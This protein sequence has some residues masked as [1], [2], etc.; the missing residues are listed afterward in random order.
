[1]ALKASVHAF[2]LRAIA[3]ARAVG[4]VSQA[5]REF[6]IARTLF[7]RWRRRYLAY[8]SDGLYPKRA[9]PRRGRPPSLSVEAERAILAVALAWPT[10]GPAR[11]S[12]HLARCEDGAWNLAPAT[13][14]WFLHRV[15]LQTRWQRLAVLE[16]Y[17]AQTAG[18]LTERT[19][20]TLAQAQ[21]RQSPHVA[22]EQPGELVCLDTFYIGKLKGVGKVWQYAACDAAYSYAVAQVSTEFSAEAAARFLTTRVL[23][24][25]QAAGWPLRRLLTDC[26]SEY[27]GVFDQACAAYGIRHTRTRPRYAWTNG[28]LERLQGTLLNELWR[29]E[30][31]RRFST[32]VRSLQ[33]AL[34]RYLE[35]YNH[36]R[37]HL[38]YRTRGRSPADLFW[39]IIGRRKHDQTPNLRC[40]HTLPKRG[41]LDYHGASSFRRASFLANAQAFATSPTSSFALIALR[42]G[43]PRKHP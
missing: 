39:G 7:Y 6:G 21:R 41:T 28:F 17:N 26:G 23:P 35:F 4:N 24:V 22:A 12:A 36:R 10:W 37:P 8:G 40:V 38:G 3:G 20:R 1:M 11:V 18:L 29:V 27:R 30:F 31:R 43:E 13:I 33:A 14:Y 2:R 32:R 42:H 34:D 9:G 15:G 25:Y 19:R 16:A 5:C